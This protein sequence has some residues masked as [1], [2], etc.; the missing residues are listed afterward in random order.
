MNS[1]EK[2]KK[3]FLDITIPTFNRKKELSNCLYRLNSEIQELSLDEKSLIRLIVSDNCSNY[4][5]ELL[6]TNI[7]K[8]VLVLVNK[9]ESNIGPYKN[10]C[11]CYLLSNSEYI[12]LLSDDD[13]ILKGKLK[14]LIHDLNTYKPDIV[15]LEFRTTNI[16]T[17]EKYFLTSPDDFLNSVN[18]NATLISSIVLKTMY[19]KKHNKFKENNFNY[20]YYTLNAIS[21]GHSFLLYN[22]QIIE[23]PY[24]NNSG[25]YSWFDVFVNELDEVI[26]N[27]NKNFNK[28][29]IRNLRHIILNKMIIPQ[30]YN[31]RINKKSLKSFSENKS[32]WSIFKMIFFRY[33]TYLN[34]YIKLPLLL[35]LPETIIRILK[36]LIK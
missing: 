11:K 6:V 34:F 28:S 30:F 20:F 22:K 9:N 1:N 16:S 27:F 21:V 17:E 2:N 23:S 29:T 32:N 14:L 10:F 36:R 13:M 4:N 15:Y 5:V 19:V 12:W 24:V 26:S 33:G 18:I 3:V 7:I 31:L 25:G 8:D 35:I